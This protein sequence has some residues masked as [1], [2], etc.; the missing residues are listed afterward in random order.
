MLPVGLIAITGLLDRHGPEYVIV[1]T[2][3]RS[4][5]RPDDSQLPLRESGSPPNQILG[6]TQD[7]EIGLVNRPLTDFEKGLIIMASNSNPR[8][9]VKFPQTSGS[10]LD[11]I[12]LTSPTNA[13]DFYTSRGYTVLQ[14]VIGS[15]MWQ[16]DK[17]R[18]P[19]E[20]LGIAY[21]EGEIETNPVDVVVF[22]TC[23]ML[24]V[25]CEPGQIAYVAMRDFVQKG[26]NVSGT[27]EREIVQEEQFMPGSRYF[28]VIR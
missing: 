28:I 19:Q 10:S 21:K 5:P 17:L 13:A 15:D 7:L 27:S 22:G 4:E 14:S 24:G 20:Y 12:E 23:L 18:L 1:F 11:N 25:A 6:H 16:E 26:N 2:G 9:P 8:L 3:L